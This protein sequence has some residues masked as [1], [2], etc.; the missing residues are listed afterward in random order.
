RQLGQGDRHEPGGADRRHRRSHQRPPAGGGGPAR[1]SP[2][3]VPM[4]W[5]AAL[6]VVAV[7]V[8]V[9]LL[10]QV[11]ATPDLRRG[12][13]LYLR[14]ADAA[15]ATLTGRLTA[16]VALEGAVAACARCHGAGGAGTREGGIAAP[17]ID[18]RSLR[19]ATARREALDD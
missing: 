8:G 10:L 4:R 1:M 7:L 2:G 6:P 11:R 18:A 15:G 9:G 5:Q 19:R 16:G 12:R 17:P 3:R 13:L 14:G